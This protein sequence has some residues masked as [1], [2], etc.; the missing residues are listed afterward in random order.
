MN[1]CLKVH[2]AEEWNGKYYERCS[3]GRLG[4]ILYLGHGGHCCPRAGGDSPLVLN[5][6]TLN[7]LHASKVV[8]CKCSEKEK[9]EQ[10]VEFHLIPATTKQPATAFSV[11]LLKFHD[12]LASVSKLST[13]DFVLSL[14]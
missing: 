2:F 3:Q 7:G 1:L 14:I 12:V 9:W 13:L 4:R 10:L 8:Y 11:R 6:V 5:V